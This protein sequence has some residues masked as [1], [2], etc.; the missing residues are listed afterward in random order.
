MSPTFFT[1]STRHD[2]ASGPGVMTLLG[3]TIAA[4][5]GWRGQE[6]SVTRPE[7]PIRLLTPLFLQSYPQ[8]YQQ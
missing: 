8:S 6:Q 1:D 2:A 5:V 7:D 4:C 3:R